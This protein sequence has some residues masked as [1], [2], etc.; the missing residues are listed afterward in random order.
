MKNIINIFI[1]CCIG[2]FVSCS[3][4]ESNGGEQRGDQV[5]LSAIF[6][7]GM[8]A[9]ETDA[10]HKLRC[11]L[12]LRDPNA[13]VVHHQEVVAEP[14]A[15][16]GKLVF[17]FALEEGTYSCQLWADYID[18]AST[19]AGE[20]N[21]YPDKYYN[22]TDLT[23]I[24]M[25][26][27][28]AMVNNDA[29]D[30]FYY[31]GELVKGAPVLQQEISM[32]RPITKISLKENNLK[33]FNLVTAVDVSLAIPASFNV[34]SGTASAE[35]VDLNHVDEAF[36]P[37]SY[38]VGTLFSV[39]AFADAEERMLG[40]VDMRISTQRLPEQHIVVDASVIPL[41]VGQHVEVSANM[42]GISPDPDTEFEI[43]YEI[44]ISDWTE[45]DQ[46]VEV[47]DVQP[48][49][50]D[51]YYA[52]GTYSSNYMADD[53]NPCIGV[54]FAVAHDDG[55]AAADVPANYIDNGGVQRVEEVHGWV[56]AARD[57]FGEA[58]LAALADENVQV[59]AGLKKGKDD[60]LGFKN[61]E[62]IKAEATL[63]D[64]P[65]AEFIVN[66][67]ANELTKAPEGTS[68]W[69]WGAAGQH[70]VLI[71]EYAEC[72]GGSLVEKRAVM[73]S[74]EILETDGIGAT[75]P[76]GGNG[77][78][79]WYSTSTSSDVAIQ[80]GFA[81]LGVENSDFGALEDNWAA[82]TSNYNARPILTF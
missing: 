21:R 41:I 23:H 57:F 47:T 10:S 70:Q 63:S 62:L 40:E 2:L 66:Y 37:A 73:Q 17:D 1:L 59:P 55:K 42:L 9:T 64:F 67:E 7:E 54:V 82:P 11:I 28:H 19:A 3:E 34:V 18:A 46:V 53:A 79:F 5:Q 43:T 31:T 14:G 65:V 32:T 6:P 69:Y 76:V 71:E 38:P 26:D 45:A 56:V 16:L 78:R 58:T 13:Q 77:R 44:E 25:I 24:S 74:L 20:G 61:T 35:T 49:V 29:C 60:I 68:G 36:N 81:C 22:T 80:M 52:D 39:F 8:R 33:E 75:F 4:D 51:F 72:E 27:T 50:G 30:A 12:E 48:K 15:D